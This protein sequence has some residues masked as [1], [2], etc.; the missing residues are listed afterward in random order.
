M[1]PKGPPAIRSLTTALVGG[2]RLPGVPLSPWIRR[3][4]LIPRAPQPRIRADISQNCPGLARVSLCIKAGGRGEHSGEGKAA[5]SDRA[6]LRQ[7]APWLG[8]WQFPPGPGICNSGPSPGFG[9][10]NS[11]PG[12]GFGFSN[13]RQDFGSLDLRLGFCRRKERQLLVLGLAVVQLHQS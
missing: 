10:G 6:L 12:L 5:I 13:F 11:R 1:Q 7:L 9:F 4:H 8:H 2:R 3:S